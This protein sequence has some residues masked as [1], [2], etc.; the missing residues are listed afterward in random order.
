MNEFLI[1]GEVL[2][3]QGVRGEAKVRPFAANPDDFMDWTTL[4]YK[5]GEQYT[6]VKAK[7]S[8][9][10]DG[11][12]YVTL[13]GCTSPDD[14]EKL[15]GRELYIDRAHA[16]EL[17]E[18]EYYIADMIGC[19]AVDEKGEEIGVLKDVLQNGPVDVYVFK[20][21]RGTMMAPAVL[22]A[23]PDVDIDARII[24]VDSERL[25][26]VAVFED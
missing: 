7:C 12:A 2:R 5:N 22:K 21:R 14:V 6:P 3:P 10:H 19:R 15:R 9:V 11:F 25:A 1:V 4:Y 18:G 20:T 24:H 26:E 17:G 23:F 8:R 13:E 16:S